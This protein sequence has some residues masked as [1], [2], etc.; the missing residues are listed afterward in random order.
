MKLNYYVKK[1][2]LHFKR[3]E[4]EKALEN[5]EKV[6]YTCDD[7]FVYLRY[8]QCQYYMNEI[9][10][11]KRYLK[12][13]YEMTGDKLFQ[14]ED[15]IFKTI[16]KE[17]ISE[18]EM[19]MMLNRYL[20]KDT[21]ENVKDEL[22]FDIVDF[23]YDSQDLQKVLVSYINKNIFTQQ[24]KWEIFYLLREIEYDQEKISL[25]GIYE[26]V[27]DLMFT[28]EFFDYS[29]SYKFAEVLIGIIDD[30]EKVYSDIIDKI[31]M[32]DPI[33]LSIAIVSTYGFMFNKHEKLTKKFL[34]IILKSLEHNI[35]NS[36]IMRDFKHFMSFCLE[37]PAYVK[38]KKYFKLEK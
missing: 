37:E 30:E 18:N 9:F 35:N 26:W 31:D 19:L 2:N 4:Y 25:E 15:K 8:G 1:A 27:L 3:K 28:K 5:L 6:I 7:S 29:L 10:E 12:K 16:A 36:N 22:L 33:T 14:S 32:N 20:S 13:A 23:I 34:D 21:F 11:A 38:Y 24:Q 17:A